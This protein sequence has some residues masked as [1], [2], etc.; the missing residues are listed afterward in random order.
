MKN[1][2]LFASLMRPT[3]SPAARRNQNIPFTRADWPDEKRAARNGSTILTPATA[4]V[5]PMPVNLLTYQWS[6]G[7]LLHRC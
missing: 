1:P 4:T 3:V 5:S 2:S 7:P 6:F